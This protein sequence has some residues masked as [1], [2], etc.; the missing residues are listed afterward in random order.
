M[1][2]FS[3]NRAKTKIVCTIGPACEEESV[4]RRMV[5]AGMS[6]AR[7]NFSHGTHE[8]HQQLYHKLRKV[9]S[10]L[11]VPLCILQ[12]LSGPKIRIGRFQEEKVFLKPGETFYLTTEEKP[13]TEREVSVDFPEM[14][15]VVRQGGRILLADGLIELEVKQVAPS[16]VKTEVMVG[17]FLSD[18][19]GIS[20]P[21]QTIPLEAMTDKDYEDLA[22]G[23]SL[24]VDYVALSFVR[25]HEDI[26]ALK[27]LI[28]EHQSEARVVAKL[29]RPEALEDLEAILD[30]TD[31]VMVARGDLGIEMPPEK[32]PL[33]QKRIIREARKRDVFVITA[34]QMLESMIQS[35]RPTRAEA[36]DVANAVLDGTDAVMLS[37]ETAT[38]KYPVRTVEIMHRIV[39]EAESADQ[40][41]FQ[42]RMED[43]IHKKMFSG[44]IAWAA[45]R[46][47][48]MTDAV[49]I[50][51]YTLSGT[52]ARLISK[53]RPPVPILGLTPSEKVCRQL[54]LAW[55]V[56]PMQTQLVPTLREMVDEVE[57][58]VQE[59]KVA[60]PGDTI[61]IVAG[62]P[63]EQQGLTNLLKIHRVGQP[64]PGEWQ[65]EGKGG[66]I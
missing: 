10:E 44:S 17:G 32:V 47:A 39:R 58:M 40:K 35:P 9:A 21:G 63:L 14:P 20:F 36:S 37:G 4:M 31:V 48:E 46:L 23:L 50:C 57:R 45:G 66:D 7:L 13:G 30:E 5:R 51:A 38:G 26:A 8:S 56:T 2:A 33:I 52:T 16:W 12:D 49:A 6:V 34:T 3:S 24:G 64:D 27:K 42:R 11:E 60:T 15:D 19:K 54:N 18:H 53:T 22:F 1:Q 29:E 62:F 28:R 55:G 41:I 59:E 43:S 61:L 65:I 25:R